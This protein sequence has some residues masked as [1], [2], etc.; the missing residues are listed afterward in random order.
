MAE[1]N[2]KI[3][4]ARLQFSPHWS[5]LKQFTFCALFSRFDECNSY[6]GFQTDS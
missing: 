6:I 4:N 1:K 5:A 2:V 3:K